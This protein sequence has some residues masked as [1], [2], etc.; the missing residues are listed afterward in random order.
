M[1]LVAHTHFCGLSSIKK[2][3]NGKKRGLKTTLTNM[4][5]Y[6]VLLKKHCERVISEDDAERGCQHLLQVEGV[7]IAKEIDYLL[8]DNQRPPVLLTS[9]GWER[10]C[11]GNVSWPQSVLGTI[12][13]HVPIRVPRS[14]FHAVIT[15]HYCV[16]FLTGT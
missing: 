10:N 12:M 2:V 15:K 3:F 4:L 6:R 9:G 14:D 1:Q 5:A 16:L 11:G 8:R 7:D 13:M